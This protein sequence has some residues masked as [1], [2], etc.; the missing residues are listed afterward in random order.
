MSRS[1]RD[2][3]ITVTKATQ[4]Q[5]AKDGFE[6]G[7]SS[8]SPEKT[9]ESVQNQLDSAKNRLVPF[10]STSTGPP[11]INYPVAKLTYPECLEEYEDLSQVNLSF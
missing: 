2:W 10:S 3:V 1:L 7:D 6:Q 9:L 4:A 11:L 5:L 8:K